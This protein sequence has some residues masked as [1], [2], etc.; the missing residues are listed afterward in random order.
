MTA[1]P[2]PATHRALAQSFQDRQR[3][4]TLRHECYLRNASID[5]IPGAAFSDAFDDA[6][7]SFSFLNDALTATVRITVV[8]PD[9]GWHDS[10]ARHVFGDHPAMLSVSG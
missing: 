4:Y 9:L 6:P 10:P 1:A 7:N 8:R 2:A 3:V 5:P